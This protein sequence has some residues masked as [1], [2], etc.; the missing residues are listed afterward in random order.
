M[1][2]K[3]K[4]F[5]I[6]V[7]CDIVMQRCSGLGCEEAFTRRNGGF[8]D[9]PDDKQYRMVYFTCGGCCGRAINRKL[10]NA[11][12]RLRDGNDIPKERIVVKLSSCMTRDSFHGP[13]CPNLDYIIKHIETLGLD[14]C[15]DTAVSKK[16]QALRNKGV[17]E[18]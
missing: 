6:V 8:A 14:Y 12:R 16:S 17:Y 7:Q 1:D 10:R 9:H 11:I 4:D 15:P 2:P 3:A 13:K 5:I 18:A